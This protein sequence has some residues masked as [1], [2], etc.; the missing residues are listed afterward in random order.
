MKFNI[1]K[2]IKVFLVI[3]SAGLMMG[4]KSCKKDPPAPPPEPRGL[5][6]IVEM[7]QV[8]ASPLVLPSATFDFQFVANQQLYGVISSSNKF[9]MKY[10]AVISNPNTTPESQSI[11]NVSNHDKAMMKQWSEALG[12][13]DYRVQFSKEAWCMVNLPMARIQGAVNGFEV[14]SSRGVAIGYGKGG[15]HNSSGLGVDFNAEYAQLDVSMAAYSPLSSRLITATNVSAQQSKKTIKVGLNLGGFQIGPSYYYSTPLASVTK[16]ALTSAVNQI[17]E[18][19][20][21]EPWFTRVMANH[22]THLVIVGGRDLNMQLG[23]E[24]FVYNEDYYWDGVPCESQYRGG[25]AA[26]G[27]AV[28]RIKLDWVGDEISRGKIIEQNEEDA[29]IGS[30]VVISKLVDKPENSTPGVNPP[31]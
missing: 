20:K 4:N 19:M 6:K 7:G 24:F 9:A 13:G 31:Q 1:K 23:D 26:P 15:A 25:G 5:K 10:T 11:L 30:K 27:N 2:I 18:G 14:V 16:D 17:A 28:A 3:S 8:Q 29:V 12:K 22:D 21:V